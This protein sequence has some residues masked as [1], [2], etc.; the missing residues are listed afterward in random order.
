LPRP[1][2]CAFRFSQPLDA[3]LL[4]PP[5]GLISCRLR[6]GGFPLQSFFPAPSQDPLSRPCAFLP[7]YLGLPDFKALLRVT[8][9]HPGLPYF[10]VY[11]GPLLSWVFILSRALAFSGMEPPSGSSSHGLIRCWHEV[12]TADALQSFPRRK[13]WLVSSETAC[14]PEVPGLVTRWFSKKSSWRFGREPKRF[15][16]LFRA[17]TRTGQHASIA[18]SASPLLG[19]PSLSKVYRKQRYRAY[20]FA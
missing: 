10:R 13:N 3:L 16:F 4:Q 20:W 2:R 5:P 14:P 7:F 6:P 15:A 1:V 18:G 17:P 9:S 11:P 19:L 12:Q 8:G